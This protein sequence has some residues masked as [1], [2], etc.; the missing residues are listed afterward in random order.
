MPGARGAR[1]RSARR[2]RRATFALAA[3]VAIAVAGVFASPASAAL[4]DRLN[5]AL[6][7]PG[8]SWR[9]TGAIA[10]DLASGRWLY[11]RNSRLSLRP[12]SNEKLVVAI[13]ALDR[14]GR[15]TRIPTEVRGEGARVGNVWRGRLV[16]KG[17]GDPTLSYR[18]LARLAARV[19]ARGITRVTGVVAG[20]E[21][22]FDRRRTASGWKASFYKHECPP[23]SALI[24]G[25]ARVGRATATDPA[26]AA[27][28]AFRRALVAAGVRVAGGAVRGT[29]RAGSARLARTFSLDV[30]TLVRRMNWRSDNFIAEMLVKV[31]G[32]RTLG[33]GTTAA[34]ARVAVAALRRRGVPLAGVRIVDGSGLSRYDR[35]T[36]R[37]IAALLVSAWS[38]ASVRAAFFYSL[39]LAGIRGGTLEDRLRRRPA[40]LN[41]RA[42]TGTTNEAS[43][44]SGYVRR[45]IAF[46]VLQNGYPIP[47]ASARAGQDRFVQILAGLY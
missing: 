40:Y 34:G 24:V 36:P 12:A 26:L 8:V 23:L 29:V 21:S 28:R 46:S 11:A 33:T 35:L 45:R 30:Q 5:R 37:S 10:V 25:R 4:G 39:P 16:L 19:R 18:D 9:L 47:W 22:Y 17:Y 20:D 6:T 1:T 3:F 13:A 41:V 15:R 14:L 7:S 43:A 2:C 31:L 44:L 32:A 27:V 42:K 38:D